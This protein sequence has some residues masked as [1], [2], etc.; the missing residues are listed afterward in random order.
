MKQVPFSQ[1]EL[2]QR[3]VYKNSE[4]IKIEQKRVSCCRFTNAHIVG[5]VNQKIGI[6]P[7]E[8]VEVDG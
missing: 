8:V 4:Y 6:R 1:V 5:D 7:Q 2:N 3:F